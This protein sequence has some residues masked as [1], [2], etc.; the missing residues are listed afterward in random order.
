MASM[1]PHNITLGFEVSG[2]SSYN[3]N[4]ILKHFPEDQLQPPRSLVEN[5]LKCRSLMKSRKGCLSTDL[6]RMSVYEDPDY[7][8]WLKS[9]HPKSQRPDNIPNELQDGSNNFNLFV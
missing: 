6:R 4:A 5:C 8:L 9:Y 1:T 2:I 7:I 3:H